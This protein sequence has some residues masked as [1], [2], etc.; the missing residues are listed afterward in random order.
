[1]AQAS[2]KK[3]EH[4]LTAEKERVGSVPKREQLAS[5]TEP[6][7]AKKDRNRAICPKHQIIKRAFTSVS[8]K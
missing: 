3:L 6:L 7:F 5:T 8:E 2:A 1:M 4:T